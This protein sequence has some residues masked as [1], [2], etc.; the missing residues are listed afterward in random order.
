[1]IDAHLIA[2]ILITFGGL[3]LVGLLA[4]LAGRQTLLPRVTL[5]L[6]AGL[7]IGPSV[8]DWLPT[9]LETG[10]RC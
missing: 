3:F 7:L 5:L 4:D 9:S 6:L 2:E 10:S 8:L 1:M